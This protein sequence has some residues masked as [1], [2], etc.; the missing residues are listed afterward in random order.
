MLSLLA[1]T[2]K[3]GDLP[4]APDSAPPPHGYTTRV[5][6]FCHVWYEGVCSREIP[7]SK[8]TDCHSRPGCC[9]NLAALDGVN[10]RR[11]AMP[12]S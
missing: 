3:L 11:R 5:A 2:R 10:L 4:S 7:S 12:A 1:E 6:R 8:Q 9:V